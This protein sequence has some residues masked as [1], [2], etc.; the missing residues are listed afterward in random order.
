MGELEFFCLWTQQ[1]R[2]LSSKYYK[3]M[4]KQ[5]DQNSYKIVIVLREACRS[6]QNAFF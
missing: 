6:I 4:K 3:L 2:C 5:V 1:C